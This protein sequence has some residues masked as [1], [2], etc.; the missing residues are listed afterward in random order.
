VSRRGALRVATVNLQHATPAGGGTASARSLA[1]AGEALRALDLDV[2]ALQE[3][4]T[5]QR[6]SGYVHQTR[7]LARLLGAAWWRFVPAEVGPRGA[8]LGVPLAGLLG[9]AAP[10]LA[11][12]AAGQPWDPAY[13]V[14]LISRLPVV[15]SGSV[16]HPGR[17]RVL[18]VGHR[19]AAGPVRR[20]GRWVVRR[21]E[22]RAAVLATVD[23]PFRRVTIGA[24]H[25]A[26]DPRAAA[27]Q[28]G[29]LAE[30]LADLAGHDGVRL[31]LG[32]LNLPPAAVQAAVDRVGGHALAPLAVGATFPAPAPRSQIDHV[33]GPA[34]L[35]GTG[36]A[37]RLPISDHLALVATIGEIT[38]DDDRSGYA[39]P[40]RP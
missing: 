10:R 7:L 18:P 40:V 23:A 5:G 39:G 25:A 16:S 30:R 8:A 24:T 20:V 22:A 28:I 6:R 21:D 26:T 37:V 36:E 3:A 31:L 32:D 1:E 12:A 27:V 14:G 9:R 13:G 2:V 15:R 29:R 17:V 35:A 19:L 4:D 33:L 38:H 34:G 11:E